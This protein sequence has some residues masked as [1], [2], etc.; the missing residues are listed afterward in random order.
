MKFNKRNVLTYLLQGVYAFAFVWIM[1]GV[2]SVFA[3]HFEWWGFWSFLV[4]LAITP[5]YFRYM[6]KFKTM[7][8]SIWVDGAKDLYDTPQHGL[9]P[10]SQKSAESLKNEIDS[11]FERSNSRVIKKFKEEKKAGIKKVTKKLSDKK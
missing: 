5:F 6:P 3:V 9:F 8:P 10:E 2:L 7:R 11:V 4:C 1:L